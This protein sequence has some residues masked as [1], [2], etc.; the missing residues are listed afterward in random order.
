MLM[1]LF[2][3][4]IGTVVAL[5]II[6]GLDRAPFG[7]PTIKAIFRWV[8]IVGYIGFVLYILYCFVLMISGGTGFP[9]LR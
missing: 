5:A 8:I 1:L 9:R 6:F 4:V 2:Y 7:D 3:L